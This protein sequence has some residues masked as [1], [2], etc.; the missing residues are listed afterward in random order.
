MYEND[1]I[2]HANSILSSSSISISN[3]SGIS[4]ITSKTA[5]TS[6]LTASSKTNTKKERTTLEMFLESIGDDIA[7]ENNGGTRVTIND[8]L[9]TYR[10]LVNQYNCKNK[11]NTLSCLTFWKIYE[12][13]LPY[14]FKLAKRY[15]CTPAT[16][17]AAEAAFAIA[18]YIARRERSRLTVKNLEITMFLKVYM[19]MRNLLS[20]DIYKI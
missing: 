7:L 13:T 10:A 16:S 19:E 11:S 8:E 9:Y 5:A 15:I 1:I 12:F 20:E 3:N 18:S 4:T 6:T 14:L 2:N 17:V